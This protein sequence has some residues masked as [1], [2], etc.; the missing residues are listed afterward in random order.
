MI[1]TTIRRLDNGLA[2]NA[3]G[4]LIGADGN[5]A[6]AVFGTSGT[7]PNGTIFAIGPSFCVAADNSVWMMPRG[8][9]GK[10]GWINMIPAP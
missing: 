7:D 10:T 5:L 2:I 9:S 3:D 8:S 6:G 4:L 1:S